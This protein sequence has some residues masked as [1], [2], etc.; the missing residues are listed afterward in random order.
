MALSVCFSAA[1]PSFST[2]KISEIPVSFTG[3][4][5]PFCWHMM[6]VSYGA[7]NYRELPVPHLSDATLKDGFRVIKMVQQIKPL[8]M[9]A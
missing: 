6:L 5:G 8:V 4:L 7:K 9:Q 2:L 1:K 3:C